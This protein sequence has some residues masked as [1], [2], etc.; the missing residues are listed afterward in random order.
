MLVGEVVMDG[1]LMP[2]LQHPIAELLARQTNVVHV[3][4]PTGYV[5]TF[6]V[7]DYV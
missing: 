7:V 6:E 3:T 2:V 4:S 5:R 1:A